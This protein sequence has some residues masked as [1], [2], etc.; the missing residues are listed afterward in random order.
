M[1]GYQITTDDLDFITK[2]KKEQLIKKLKVSVV[3]F[4]CRR[5][6]AV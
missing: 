3:S 2:L 5:A 6:A 4:R 1:K